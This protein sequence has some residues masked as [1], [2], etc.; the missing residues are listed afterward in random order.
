MFLH[1]EYHTV[2]D[3]EGELKF[4]ILYEKGYGYVLVVV[5]V[6]RTKGEGYTM[7]EMGAYTGYRITVVHTNRKSSTKLKESIQ[8][9]TTNKETLI[10]N[11]FKMHK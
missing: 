9:I 5:P 7:E 3:L 10:S 4:A 11:Y 8:Y 1:K 6:K 2:P